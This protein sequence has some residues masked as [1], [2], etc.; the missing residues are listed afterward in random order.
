MAVIPDV[1]SEY[2]SETTYQM[3]LNFVS[4]FL[5]LF[6]AYCTCPH[7]QKDGFVGYGQSSDKENVA[8]AAAGTSPRWLAS[9]S[10][11]PTVHFTEKWFMG[12][13][14]VW[15]VAFAATIVFRLHESWSSAGIFL[16]MFSLALPLLVQPVFF[17]RVTGEED[18][19]L[20]QR[21][22]LKA[23][24]WIAVFSF[25]GNWWYTHYFYSV[26][27]AHYTVTSWDANGV[28]IP[29][30][31]ATHFYF[32]FYHVVAN[33][34]LRRIATSLPPSSQRNCFS[35]LT[36]LCLAYTT[37]FMETLT[38]AGYPCYMFDDWHSAA[39]I[40]SAFYGIYF[41]VSFPMFFRLCGG[42]LG[43]MSI[44]QGPVPSRSG[45]KT[46]SQRKAARAA[47]ALASDNAA[48]NVSL[49]QAAMDAFAT[50]MVV[51]CLLDFVRVYLGQDLVIKLLR[52][53]KL[54]MSLTCAPNS[55][56]N[57]C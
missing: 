30:F 11:H 49:F 7:H 3:T 5:A 29:M 39:T 37:A 16:F 52:P 28:P 8:A 20:M 48:S 31:F 46:R 44:V 40:G 34:V 41:I 22:S 17:P 13:G 25:I 56:T 50:G 35:A 33:C 32:C 43:D 26:L 23:T 24:V 18:I 54:D 42:S 14:V 21:F 53:C 51:L 15:M 1:V 2:M 19:P 6:L 55:G 45:V 10:L 38:I 47:E 57:Y 4:M 12:Y 27:G 9:K 36:V